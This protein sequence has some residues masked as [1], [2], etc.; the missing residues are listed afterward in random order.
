MWKDI[1][2]TTYEA[3]DDGEVRNKS[4]GRVLKQW[5]RGKYLAVWLGAHN[6]F[7]VHKI[8]ASLFHE[9]VDGY[10]IDHINRNK[11]DNRAC[12]LRYISKSANR[13]NTPCLQTNSLGQKN[14]SKTTSGSY[15]VRIYRD[16]A[17]VLLKALIL[18]MRLS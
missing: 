12:N 17:Y 15:C 18:W 9:Q 1:P 2:G 6:P 11:H 3:S 4:T 8:I 7:Y 13:C 10:D 5:N 16:G 14:I